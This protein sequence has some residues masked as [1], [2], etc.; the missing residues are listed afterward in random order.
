MGRVRR[1]TT[2][3]HAHVLYKR[4][5]L[6]NGSAASGANE[7]C[8]IENT[9]SSEELLENEAGVH[10]DV[11]V[12]G[13]KLAQESDLVV[14]LAVFVDEQLWRHFSSRHG[15]LAWQK[16]QQYALTML[17]NI[18]ARRAAPSAKF[19]STSIDSFSTLL[20]YTFGIFA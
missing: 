11:F 9:I 1:S 10:E 2:G 15:S 14:E 20:K 3:E 19:P 6:V 4:E 16:L 18:Q 12:V 8:G 13:Q 5:S 17:S 7:F